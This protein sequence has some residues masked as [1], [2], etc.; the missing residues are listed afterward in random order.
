ML[1]SFLG[2]DI[3]SKGAVNDIAQPRDFGVAPARRVRKVTNF[4][5]AA[6]VELAK[7]C[8]SQVIAIGSEWEVAIW[9]SISNSSRR[10]RFILRPPAL[11]R[12]LP[13]SSRFGSS[14]RKWKPN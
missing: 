3:N 13:I 14:T 9:R 1:D 7:V 6:F 8:R 12:S 4:A 2:L 11:T 10:R 5:N